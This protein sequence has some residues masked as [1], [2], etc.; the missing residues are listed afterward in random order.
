MSIKKIIVIYKTHL[1]IGFTDF[2]KNVVKKYMNEFIPNAL[3]VA[4]ELRESNSNERLIW[5]TGS[6]LVYEYL[7]T[8]TGEA[9]EKLV[10]GIEKGDIR[11]HGLPFTTHTEFMCKELFEYGISISKKLDEEF[12]KTTIAAKMTDVPGHTRAIIPHLR[13]AGIEFLHIGVNPASTVPDVPSIFRWKAESGQMLT[14]MYQK[15]YGEFS[16]IGNTDVAVYFAHT[17]DNLGVQTKE[18][19]QEIFK[20][21]KKK[22]PQAEIVAGDLNDLAF[23]VRE[24]ESELPILTEEI[25]DTWIH[26]M[27]TD[28]KKVSQ[29]RALERLYQ[30]MPEGTD[31]DVLAR[32]LIMIPEH[33]WGMDVKLHLA[34]HEHY[35]KGSFKAVRKV[36]K[37]Y[38]NMKKSWEEQRNYLYDAIKEMKKDWKKEA[39]MSIKEATREEMSVA[40]MK[41]Y[42]VGEHI[43]LQGYELSFNVMGEIDS[44]RNGNC[45]IADDK[46]RLLILRYEQ[47]SGKDYKEF[48][49]QYNRLNVEWAREDFMKIGMEKV[50]TERYLFHP[51]VVSIFY[52]ENQVI[53]KYKFEDFAYRE[54]GCPELMEAVLTV[55]DEQLQ[56][57]VA[58]FGKTANRIAEAIWVGFHPIASNKRVSKLGTL[59]ETNRVVPKGQ[60]RLHATDYGVVYDELTIETVDTALVAPQ[61]PSLLEFSDEISND[62]KVF[63]NLYNN[64]WGTNFPM[65][66]E[67]DARFR[68]VIK[69]C[70]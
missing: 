20:D 10:Q 39:E 35:D 34:D 62:S 40:E 48:F 54:C 18:D 29:F 50:T 11:W 16:R 66:Y 17:G 38:L 15:D 70:K 9:R 23:A 2:S 7:R 31:K 32:G 1:D 44:L 41:E 13:K 53:V 58:W 61:E 60:C 55:Q 36:E 64:I 21:L 28:P 45:V 12:H 27:G 24:I 33:T 67:E 43:W 4:K 46:H 63:F 19:I 47:F 59:I 68:F 25:G 65:W 14:V 5:T 56:I 26:G 42:Q 8:H 37:N 6:W 49:H 22:M 57:D 52:D 30:R 3:S 69:F 51:S